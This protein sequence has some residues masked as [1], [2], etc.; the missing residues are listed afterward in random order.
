MKY[1]FSL[2]LCY[3]KP[4]KISSREDFSQSFPKNC[5]S[6]TI[7]VEF[8]SFKKSEKIYNIFSEI[9]LTL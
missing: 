3:K 8:Q 4:Y 1:F 6:L 7:L 2:I 9:N 5:G